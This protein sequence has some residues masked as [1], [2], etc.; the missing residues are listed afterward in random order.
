M[1]RILLF[2]RLNL[3]FLLVL[4]VAGNLALGV[5]NFVFQPIWRAAAVTAAVATNEVKSEAEERRAVA[6]ARTK[7]KAKARLRRVVTV[8][9]FVGLAA[10]V[11]FEYAD[12]QAWLEENPG[13]DAETYGRE[14]MEVSQEVADEVLADLPE[15]VGPDRERLIAGLEKLMSGFAATAGE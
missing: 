13:G 5:L 11:G 12:Y 6:K 9:P 15:R 4:S 1:K 3:A 10:A 8:L 14:V 7:E 2:L